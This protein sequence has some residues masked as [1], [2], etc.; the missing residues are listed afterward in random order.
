MFILG[1]IGDIIEKGFLGIM[2]TIDAVIYTLISSAYKVFM[3]IAGA[4]LLTSDA[5]V[6]VS[7]QVYM[8]IGVIMLFVLAYSILR[9][10]VNPDNV[11]SEY[12]GPKFIQNILICVIGLAASQFVFNFMYQ[13]QGIILEEDVLGKIFFR[14]D[15]SEK[16]DYG[17]LGSENPDEYVEELGG[18]VTATSLWEAFF[19]PSESSGLSAEEITVDPSDLVI[20]GSAIGLGCIVAS[21]GIIIGVATS[22]SGAGAVIAGLAAGVAGLLCVNAS[23]NEY[24]A[25]KEL[26]EIVG[27]DEVSLAAAYTYTSAGGTFNVYLGFIDE[28]ADN[29]ITYQVIVSTIG[30]IFALYAFVSFSI[31]M[32]IRCAKLAYYQILA[33]VPLVMRIIPGKESVFDNYVKA[34]L[35]TFAEVFVRISIVYINMYIISH[36][37]TLFST[38]SQLW[39]NTSLSV[40]ERALAYALIIIG[41]L[42]FCRIAPDVI[43]KTL[44]IDTSDVKLGIREKLGEGGVYS[45]GAIVGSGATSAIHGFRDAWKKNGGGAKGLAKGIGSAARGFGAGAVRAGWNQFGLNGSEAKS[46]AD[47]KATATT[48]SQAADDA[49]A[50]RYETN[51]KIKAARDKIR[52]AEAEIARLSALPQTA[53]T[54]SEIDRQEE[55]I[56]EARKT[57]NELRTEPVQDVK[58]KI[59]VWATG[60]VDLS[61]EQSAISFGNSIGDLQDKLRDEAYKKD[62]ATKTLAAREA[63][64]KENPVSEFREGWTQ[65]SYSQKVKELVENDQEIRDAQDDYNNHRIDERERDRRIKAATERITNQVSQ[66][67][68]LSEKEYREKQ[69]ERQTQIDDF[70]KA[71]EAAADLYVQKETLKSDSK[72]SKMVQEFISSNAAFIDKNGDKQVVTLDS[73]GNQ[74]KRTVKEIFEETLGRKTLGGKLNAAEMI[75]LSQPL[76][77]TID[78]SELTY[79]AKV[80]NNGELLYDSQD[81][82][83]NVV[84]TDLKFSDLA[85]RMAT[86]NEIKVDDS[87]TS[88]Q[89]TQNAGKTMATAITMSDEYREAQ[90]AIR[91][92]ND[93]K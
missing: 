25:G 33:P 61:F 4:R 36:L 49:R 40:P 84:D 71:K 44:G 93:K 70:R 85:E 55:I 80:G 41:L 51:D 47:A 28:V 75:D 26:E 62:N 82:T 42:A 56:K 24:E 30:G 78:G 21:A 27:D 11:F 15:S 66:V 23:V 57:I 46:Y 59:K 91:E 8:L 83:G 48:A 68:K 17:E 63:E 77:I 5:Y 9:A 60:T 74:I 7:N 10:I 20:G 38:A 86:A 52:D 18:A 92:A 34:V 64:L 58:K 37:Y 54:M 67:A 69:F 79:K 72:V 87:L 16:L 81:N 31:D 19:Y 53:Q 90:T 1:T 88:I 6:S 2:I 14:T 13:A 43:S 39:G 35:S 89:R 76:K 73:N 12:L 50:H 29:N 22:W 32:G 45:G 65:E 3:A